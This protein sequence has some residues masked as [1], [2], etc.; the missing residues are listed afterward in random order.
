MN[1]LY[2]YH[3]V[4]CSFFFLCFYWL[5]VCLIGVDSLSYRPV[6]LLQLLVNRN[7]DSSLFSF[8]GRSSRIFDFSLASVVMLSL[9]SLW[10]RLFLSRVPGCQ[11]SDCCCGL[12]VRS[13]DSSIA[14]W[15][16]TLIKSCIISGF[17]QC[18][19]AYE[20]LSLHA[21]L[22]GNLKVTLRCTLRQFLSAHV[23]LITVCSII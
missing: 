6:K 22:V 5:C 8:L 15:E 12:V 9:I 3:F 7:R 10:Q 18:Y 2:V 21:P 14:S 4:C 1:L 19:V 23:A 11:F 17:L 20:R 13:P 16:A